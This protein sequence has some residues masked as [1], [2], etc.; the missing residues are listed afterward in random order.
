MHYTITKTG[1]YGIIIPL[2]TGILATTLDKYLQYERQGKQYMANPSWAICHLYKIKKGRGT[3][4][5]GLLYIVKAIMKK[6]A[7]QTNNTYKIEYEYIPKQITEWKDTELRDYQK[8]AIIALNNSGNGI[9]SAPTG[10][11][12]SRIIIEYIKQKNVPTLIIIP[13]LDL[14]SQWEKQ[15]I[16]VDY[17]VMTYQSIKDYEKLSKYKLIIF[18]ECHIVGADTIYRTA[19][20]TKDSELCGCS[21]TPTRSD[22]NEMKVFAAL[23]RIVYNISRKEL[24]DRGILNNAIVYYYKI[25][26]VK[27]VEDR[28]MD[29]NSLYTKQIINNEYRNNLIIKIALEEYNNHRKILILVDQV[30]HYDL[31]KEK[32]PIGIKVYSVNGLMKK[33]ERKKLMEQIL[34][35]KVCIVL[36]T[37]VFDLG[38][39]IPDMDTVIL[40]NAGKSY[41]RITQRI[42]RILRNYNGKDIGKII[43][44]EDNPKW[45]ARQTIARKKILSED[46]EVIEKQL[47]EAYNDK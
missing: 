12:K 4:P 8:D 35:E 19:M 5:F 40:G 21:A 39:N 30:K 25:P 44:F 45:L 1:N 15:R 9:I 26:Y 47:I 41:I 27:N 42:G 38:V 16:G 13:T 29:Y 23:G 20:N 3:F 34:G 18:D 43:D 10:S 7:S 46:F 28:Y 11:G 17:D 2:P 36:A 24:I 31:L 33:K 14:M 22:G 32:I 6:Y 37:T